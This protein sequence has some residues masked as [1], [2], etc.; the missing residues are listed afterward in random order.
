MCQVDVLFESE[1]GFWSA[2][3]SI[4]ETAKRPVIMTAVGRCVMR[5]T[6]ALW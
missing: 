4:V 2:V 6:L 1:N 3:S 5:I